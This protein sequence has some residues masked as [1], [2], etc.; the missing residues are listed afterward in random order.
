M[1]KINKYDF[2]SNELKTI[3]DL[4]IIKEIS[5]NSILIDKIYLTRNPNCPEDII[6]NIFCECEN[7]NVKAL[8][9]SFN[10]FKISLLKKFYKQPNLSEFVKEHIINH[11]NWEL[12]DFI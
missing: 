5:I 4:E 3:S 10:G 7:D 9:L 2:S 6:I 12:N 11:P 8:I 1:N